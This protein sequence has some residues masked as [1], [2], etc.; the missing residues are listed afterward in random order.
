MQHY[1][2]RLA[3][4]FTLNWAIG[5]VVVW[6]LYF[7]LGAAQI[8]FSFLRGHDPFYLYVGPFNMLLGAAGV[9]HGWQI[10]RAVVRRI[11]I[12][13]EIESVSHRPR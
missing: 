10:I 4:S 7:C 3:R 9:F 12:Q 6:T 1:Y 2:D 11:T 8:F 13:P 5:F